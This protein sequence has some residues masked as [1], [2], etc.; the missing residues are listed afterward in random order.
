V[1]ARLFICCASE[2]KDWWRRYRVQLNNDNSFEL[3][4]G[5]GRWLD[6]ENGLNKIRV[7]SSGIESALNFP[8]TDTD[9]MV[10]SFSGDSKFVI[11]RLTSIT[12]KNP[13]PDVNEM[14]ILDWRE[15]GYTIPR[16]ILGYSMLIGMFLVLL[17]AMILPIGIKGYSA[18]FMLLWIPIPLI[19]LDMI[20]RSLIGLFRAVKTRA[21]FDS[22]IQ[23]E[24]SQ[25][26]IK[27]KSVLPYLLTVTAIIL[28][29]WKLENLE[30]SIYV[31]IL[32]LVLSAVIIYRFGRK[33]RSI[34]S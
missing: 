10:A 25:Q 17:G 9:T 18:L 11:S 23:I 21:K 28:I 16:M 2:Q 8:V 7:S 31:K 33:L 34:H 5:E 22:I 3:R 15:S 1:R 26:T 19:L 12:L 13:T 32:S 20:L 24:P 30:V 14:A 4:S 6:L 27:S 29:N